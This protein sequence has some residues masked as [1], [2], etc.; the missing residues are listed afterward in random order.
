MR[1]SKSWKGKLRSNKPR[2]ES[3]TLMKLSAKLLTG[4]IA[5]HTTSDSNCVPCDSASGGYSVSG[6]I[7]FQVDNHKIFKELTTWQTSSS[8]GLT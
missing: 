7:L 8:L 3:F 2:L 5:Y 6:V 4:I 1:K